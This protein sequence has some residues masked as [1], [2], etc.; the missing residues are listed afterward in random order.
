MK[1]SI[2]DVLSLKAILNKHDRQEKH[3]GY[4]ILPERFN[5]LIAGTEHEN[6]YAYY[7]KERFAFFK[8]NVQFLGAKIIDIGCN[9]G[10]FLFG[11]LDS[12]AKEVTGYEGKKSCG[13][14]LEQA[15]LLLS[16]KNNFI[17]N[18]HYYQFDD[19]SEKYDIG[20]LLNVIHHTG[21]DYH[22]DKT[23]I[24]EA[25]ENMLKQVNLL[26]HQI[27]ILIFQM[28][29]NWKGNRNLCLFP[30]GTKSEM[31]EFIQQGTLGYWDVTCIGI[32]EKQDG[33]VRYKKPNDKNIKR[34][35]ALGEFL[36]RPVF[37]LKSR[38][39]QGN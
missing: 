38:Q 36:N 27:G 33:V 7:E 25:K 29:Y 1:A 21:D 24:D 6:K 32:P 15:V 20:L 12:G 39:F 31:I 30:N 28:G 35:D 4:H 10:Y 9:T 16:D 23:D 22:S 19:A 3:I 18:N 13:D 17:V 37:I 26:S 8:D 34:N 2:E 14:F 5:S 11:A